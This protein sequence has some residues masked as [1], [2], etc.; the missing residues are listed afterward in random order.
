[1]YETFECPYDGYS[2]IWNELLKF[3]PNKMEFF[4]QSK[5][6]HIWGTLTYTQQLEK[7]TQLR[8]K[9]YKPQIKLLCSEF[10]KTQK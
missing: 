5:F 7:F 3:P 6:L 1:M 4:P 10:L 9:I 2:L 8:T